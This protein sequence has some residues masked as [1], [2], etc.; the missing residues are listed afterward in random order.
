[1]VV[2]KLVVMVMLML[3]VIGEIDRDYDVDIG[4]DVYVCVPGD[5]D[6]DDDFIGAK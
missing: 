5:V 2:S 4:D 1:M 6:G 3:M